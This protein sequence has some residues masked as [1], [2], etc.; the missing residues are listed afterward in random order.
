MPE[1]RGLASRRQG[2]PPISD[3][4]L[5]RNQLGIET[6]YGHVVHSPG[7]AAL[8]G[9][10]GDIDALLQGG[11]PNQFNH[12]RNWSDEYGVGSSCSPYE[13]SVRRLRK[14]LYDNKF[15]QMQDGMTNSIVSQAKHQRNRKDS[16]QLSDLFTASVRSKCVESDGGSGGGSSTNQQVMNLAQGSHGAPPLPQGHDRYARASTWTNRPTSGRGSMHSMDAGDLNDDSMSPPNA[17]AQYS[18]DGSMAGI[19]EDDRF[20]LTVDNID[21]KRPNRS[22][23]RRDEVFDSELS[24]S[25]TKS[26]TL[27]RDSSDFFNPPAERVERGFSNQYVTDDNVAVYDNLPT[28]MRR[29]QTA[30]NSTPTGGFVPAQFHSH[31]LPSAHSQRGAV[32]GMRRHGSDRQLRDMEIMAAINEG[33]SSGSAP[34]PY[35]VFAPRDDTFTPGGTDGT[36]DTMHGENLNFSHTRGM[37]DTLGMP[38]GF[39]TVGAPGA[40]GATASSGSM[41]TTVRGRTVTEREMQAA[42]AGL[43]NEDVFLGM[44]GDEE[45]QVQ[46]EAT[47]N[48][49]MSTEEFIAACHALE[50]ASKEVAT[51]TQGLE[52]TADKHTGKQKLSSTATFTDLKNIGVKGGAAKAELKSKEKARSNTALAWNDILAQKEH[53]KRLQYFKYHKTIEKKLPPL[54]NNLLA[55]EL[56]KKP[57]YE[58]VE[59]NVS[60]TVLESYTPAAIA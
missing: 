12:M 5:R 49:P 29:R 58:M 41:D 11:N 22:A 10:M 7:N 26:S 20:M 40:F 42:T 31:P 16:Q 15:A 24:S 50:E 56:M 45:E 52:V 9:Q 17:M 19:P 48:K 30:P 28:A 4:V 14:S 46:K 57:S 44:D 47:P 54:R 37:S 36:P 34:T 18:Q 51:A 2:I 23:R 60:K 59:K 3:A 55:P 32:L 27:R 35:D 38:G 8:A 25:E 33:E 21:E 6:E 1:I 13:G 39:N 43:R 53:R